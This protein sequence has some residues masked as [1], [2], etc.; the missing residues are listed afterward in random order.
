MSSLYR[1]GP[2]PREREQQGG[3][4]QGP[5]PSLALGQVNPHSSFFCYILNHVA[6]LWKT[7]RGSIHPPGL[8]AEIGLASAYVSPDSQVELWP[9]V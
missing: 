4:P 7:V 8:A 2:Q 3:P 5:G 9:S 1:T 6:K